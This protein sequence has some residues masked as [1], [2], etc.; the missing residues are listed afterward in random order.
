MKYS[1]WPQVPPSLMM[2]SQPS[3]WPKVMEAAPLHVT[4]PATYVPS[5]R[6]HEVF[7][8]SQAPLTQV[9]PAVH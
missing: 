7:E 1:Y 4:G 3:D 8:N 2:M 5:V 6:L 9:D